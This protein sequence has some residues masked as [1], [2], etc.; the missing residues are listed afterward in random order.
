MPEQRVKFFVFLIAD[1]F[2]M[3]TTWM[4]LFVETI[5]PPNVKPDDFVVAIWVSMVIGFLT[6][7]ASMAGRTTF[8][9]VQE[10]IKNR[11]NEKVNKEN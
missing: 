10:K 11:K 2:G 7:F 5:T 9:Y 1:L 4:I 3:V 6:G 8:S